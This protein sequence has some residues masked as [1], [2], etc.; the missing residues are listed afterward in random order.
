[1]NK[2]T[3]SVYPA[4]IVWCAVIGLCVS[5]MPAGDATV[6]GT[7]GLRAEG[8]GI[9]HTRGTGNVS[10]TVYGRGRLTVRN[11]DK[12]NI[13]ATGSG[14]RKVVGNTVVFYG[15]RGTVKVS[16]GAIDCRFEG[17]RINYTAHGHGTVYLKGH[18]KY[19]TKHGGPLPWKTT[20]TTVTL[21]GNP[22][23]DNYDDDEDTYMDESQA[24]VE[25]LKSCDAYK[26]WAKKHPQ[27]AKWLA[28][29]GD[30]A[31]FLENHPNAAAAFFKHPNYAA[32]AKAHPEA[33]KFITTARDYHAWR[34]AHPYYGKYFHNPVTWY[35]WLKNHPDAADA[36]KAGKHKRWEA[37][38]EAHPDAAAAL[39]RH[40]LAVKKRL[41][42]NNDGKITGKERHSVWKRRA[43]ANKDGKVDAH[44]RKKS[45]YDRRRWLRYTDR[46]RDGRVQPIERAKS[47]RDRRRRHANQ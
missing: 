2:T 1:M 37:F 11:E 9:I 3:I 23:A 24:T 47:L 36:L 19:W 44:E 30:L 20:G 34:K 26:Y 38:A 28:E 32:W 25:D 42:L 6:S 15:Y 13:N 7:G 27:A 21:G 31:G 45:A 40:D 14:R 12:V 29:H 8:T 18:G 4:V 10:H 35:H 5:A 22:H 17:G 43:D 46:N 16:G 41:D 39:R 33:A